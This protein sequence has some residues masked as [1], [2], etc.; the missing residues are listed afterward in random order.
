MTSPSAVLTPSFQQL[1]AGGVS[2]FIEKA[3]NNEIA[4]VLRENF[5]QFRGH[6]PSP[7]EFDSWNVSLKELA[8]L[9]READLPHLQVV[10]ELKLPVSGQRMDALL[11][12]RDAEGN[13]RAL[14]VEL[15]QWKAAS[16]SEVEDH[17]TLSGTSTGALHAHPSRQAATYAELLRDWHDAFHGEGAVSVSACALLHNARTD[18]CG[19]LLA[20]QYEKVMARAPVF[21]GNQRQAFMAYVREQ[22]GGGEAG[23]ALTRVLE[24]KSRPSKRLLDH[25]DQELAGHPVYTLVGRQEQ[26]F[27]LVRAKLQGAQ[28]AGQRAVIIIKGGPGTGK[29]VIAVRLLGTLA[30]EG[31]SVVH[32]TGSKAF[33]TNLKAT[34]SRDSASFFKYFNNFMHE[35]SGN[36]DVLVADEAHRIRQSSNSRF[37]KKEARSDRAQIE[38][39][40]DAAKVSVFLLDEQQV[41]RPGEVGTPD[42]IEAA[43]RAYGAEVHVIEL[44]G[45][46]RCSGSPGYLQWLNALLGLGGSLDTAWREDYSFELVDSPAELEERLQDKLAQKF[47]ARMMAGFCWPWSNPDKNNELLPDVVIG[48]WKR[49]W[50]RKEKGGEPPHKHPYTLWAKEDSSFNEVGCIYSVQGFEFDYTGVIFGLDL[51]VRDGHW[52]AQKQHSQDTVVKRAGASMTDLLQ[53]TYRV[54]LSRGMRGTLVHVMDPETRL[55]IE[56]A[57]RGEGSA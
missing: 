22:V 49:P 17:V 15:K 33:T 26:A 13:A 47:S 28:E 34:V 45:Q 8:Y 7:S 16:A 31:R 14:V 51:V 56:R 18:R 3:L 44:E 5:E 40:I 52:V 32:A 23:P 10:L 9:L 35:P 24:G 43:A 53:H 11:V 37:T 30:R 6:R 57:L 46:F 54:L 50:N 39:L 21:M 4:D 2:S 29:S 41:V 19:D 20:P 38:E 1:F 55:H 25:V 42:L 48:D 12:G 36:F 27:Q